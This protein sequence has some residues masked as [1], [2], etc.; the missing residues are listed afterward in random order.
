MADAGKGKLGMKFNSDF[1]FD[2]QMGQ[3]EEIWLSDLLKSK[4]VE[5]KRDYMAAKTGNLFVEFESRGKASGL[6]TTR[7]DFW[8]FILDGERVIILPTE[9][10]KRVCREIF[11]EGRTVKGGDSNTSMGVLVKIEELVK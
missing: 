3:A 5:V 4:T 6:A 7:A 1:A 2:L 10:L 8:A 9:F 11:K